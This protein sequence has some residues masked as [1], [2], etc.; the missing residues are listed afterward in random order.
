MFI[1]TQDTPNPNSL[2]FLPGCSVLA[3]EQGST[4]TIDFPTRDSAARR[5]PLAK[6]LFRIDGVVGVFFAHDFI[7]VSKQDDDAVEWRALKPEI[8]AT[9][10]DF[11]AS[12]Q[13]VLL[14]E[15][16]SD[17]SDESIDEDETSAL[18]RELIETRIRPVVQEDGGDLLFR[19][20]SDG[21]VRLKMQGACS[22]CPSSVVTL[23]Q[24]V[25]NMLQFYVPEVQSVEEVRDELDDAAAKE[26]EKFE[27]AMQQ[28][29]QQRQASSSDRPDGDSQ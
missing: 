3:D 2:K 13:P 26:F 11:F 15:S 23:K 8:Y 5:S 28:K 25:Q 14:Q 9:I 7:T 21:V 16:G 22:S 10:M 17:E 29:R 18:I 19:G 27:K 6:L 24:G 20:F 1:Q 4:T 12:G